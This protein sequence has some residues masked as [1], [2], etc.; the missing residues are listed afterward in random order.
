[1]TNS[2]H[3][4]FLEK[5]NKL[6]DEEEIIL[7]KN[8]S[9]LLLEIHGVR[10]SSVNWKQEFTDEM[11]LSL[12]KHGLIKRQG[13]KDYVLIDLLKLNTFLLKD[14]S[15]SRLIKGNSLFNL[16]INDDLTLKYEIDEKFGDKIIDLV[17]L[18]VLAYYRPSLA[19][20]IFDASFEDL[21]SKKI[22]KLFAYYCAK[23]TIDL[24]IE[25]SKINPRQK[26]LH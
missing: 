22:Y 21:N 19:K 23:F 4:V 3:N 24:I 13:L 5:I 20:K 17:E 2:I 15:V 6:S 25:K 9:S 8:I 12:F 11:N 14:R 7:A 10:S 16:V 18:N 1:M 26:E